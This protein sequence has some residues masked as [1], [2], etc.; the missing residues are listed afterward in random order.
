ME[1]AWKNLYQLKNRKSVKAWV[2]RIARNE[3]NVF[4]RD[5]QRTDSFDGPESRVDCE[6][7]EKAEADILEIL[8]K[9]ERSGL[10]LRAFDMLSPRYREIVSLW[11]LGDLSQKEIA[12][13][14]Q[15][16]YS[17]M[18]VHLYRGLNELR[19]LYFALERGDADE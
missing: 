8:L 16:N 3:V 15:M 11:A 17:T 7:A 5:T 18:R 10:L 13:V 4:F 6:K 9:K 1:K 14:L 19:D 2:Y 12:R